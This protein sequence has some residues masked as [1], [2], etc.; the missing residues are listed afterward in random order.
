VT[1][2]YHAAL[3]SLGLG[4]PVI[5]LYQSAYYKAK[6]SGLAACFKDTGIQLVD[7]KSSS[8]KRDVLGAVESLMK[9]ECR[10]DLIALRDEQII[11]ASRAY[12]N[13]FDTLVQG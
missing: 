1:G 11:M 12:D 2:S 13:F 5:C 10:K 7:L 9:L 8:L 6:F 4:I 3:F